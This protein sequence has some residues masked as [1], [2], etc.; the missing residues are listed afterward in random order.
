MS[1]A[2]CQCPDGTRSYYDQVGERCRECGRYRASEGPA[3]QEAFM[4]GPMLPGD[5]PVTTTRSKGFEGESV[6]VDAIPAPVRRE[7]LKRLLGI[8]QA[9]AQTLAN[10]AAGMAG[11]R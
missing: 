9:E 8:E 3:E 4:N 2:T 5:T 11:E 10:I 7:A 1:R 6:E